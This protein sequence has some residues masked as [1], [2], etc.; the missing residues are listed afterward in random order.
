MTLPVKTGG[1]G[2]IFYLKV[3]NSMALSGLTAV[4][5]PWLELGHSLRF[6]MNGLTFISC[7]SKLLNACS[8]SACTPYWRTP[9]SLAAELFSMEVIFYGS[10]KHTI[11]PK[12]T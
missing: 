10:L 8:I 6:C 11:Y 7:E 4:E 3:E 9:G 5:I 1:S 2:F 12:E